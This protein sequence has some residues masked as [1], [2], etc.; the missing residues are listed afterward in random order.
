[1]AHT[2]DIY[3]PAV[4]GSTITVTSKAYEAVY[5]GEGYVR[6]RQG[7]PRASD[8]GDVAALQAQNA[9][10]LRRLSALEQA[11]G[12]DAMAPLSRDDVLAQP[13]RRAPRKR[14]PRKA[15]APVVPAPA[16]GP[17]DIGSQSDLD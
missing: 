4:P 9:E 6:G 14:A 12:S 16:P 3:N 11:N 2:V 10:L 7:D 17:A 15:A 1:M 8:G 5:S 13:V